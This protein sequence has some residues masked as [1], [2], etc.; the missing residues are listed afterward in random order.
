M[1]TINFVSWNSR[2]N[3]IA[4]KRVNHNGW[5]DIFVIQWVNLRLGRNTQKNISGTKPHCWEP[6]V[7]RKNA[8]LADKSCSSSMNGSD[9][10]QMSYNID[11]RLPL[12][13]V[14]IWNESLWWNGIAVSCGDRYSWIYLH[15]HMKPAN[16]VKSTRI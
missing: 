3:R 1:A 4:I 11:G 12:E 10:E 9:L 13:V 15:N 16:K 8:P 5:I 7:A 2:T 14:E 6:F